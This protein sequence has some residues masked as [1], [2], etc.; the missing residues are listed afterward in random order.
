MKKNSNLFQKPTSYGVQLFYEIIKV[1]NLSL[2]V[3]FN[4]S[5]F[6]TAKKNMLKLLS[7][8]IILNIIDKR[9]NQYYQILVITGLKK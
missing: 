2:V 3:D 8:N 1:R 7:N 6:Q 5:H 4:L 9:N